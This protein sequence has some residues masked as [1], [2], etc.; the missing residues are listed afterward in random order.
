MDIT[1]IIPLLFGFLV[2]LF[3]VYYWVRRAEKSGLTGKDMNKYNGN[4]VAESGGISVI[5]GFIIGVLV[6]VAIETFYIKENK[7]VAEIFALVITFLSIAFIGFIDDI[8]NWKIGLSKKTR[9]LLILISSIP[10]MVINAGESTMLGINFG[11]FYPL[12][13]IPISILCASVG[14]NTIAG[15][16]GLETRQAILLFLSIL[17]VTYLNGFAWLSFISLIM[18]ISLLGFYIFNKYPAK[19]FPGNVLTYATGA[20]FAVIAILGNIEKIAIF[21][22]IPYI[23]EVGLKLRG[24]LEKESYA[25]PNYDGSLE[26]PY[27]KIYGLEHLSILIL[28]KIKPNKKVYE[29]DVVL[30]INAFQILIILIGLIIFKVD[31]LSF[32]KDVF[33]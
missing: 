30:L 33:K 2:T 31:V 13:F 17:I 22:F 9:I 1:L 3:S 23:I 5:L 25:K 4:Q 29:K 20:L 21:F 8:L 16:N 19:V 10:L 11:I 26:M 14:F 27:D 24:K 12:I 28:K 7:N 6:Y 15:Y 32:L 18:I